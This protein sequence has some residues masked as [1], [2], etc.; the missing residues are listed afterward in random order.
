MGKRRGRGAEGR[1]VRR[2]K[3]RDVFVGRPFE[4]MPSETEWV[5]LRE[6]VP[7][8]T[9]PVRL[10]D[11]AHADRAVIVTSV[12]PLA[13]PALVKP[14]GRIFLAV[15]CQARSGDLSRDLAA[16]LELALVAGPT[17][18]V[19]VTDL[20]GPGP[21]LQDLLVD[22]ALDLTLHPT[23]G[24]WLDDE[25]HADP[26][27][28]ASLERANSTILPTARL[29]AAPSAYWCRTPEKAHLRWVLPQ[30]EDTAL[31]AVARLYAAGEIGL[32]EGT[33]YVGAFRAH[34]LLVPVWDLPREPAPD[35]YEDALAV[36]ASRYADALA[37]TGPLTPAER[38]VR[39]GLRGRQLTLR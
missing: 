1:R 34:G 16:A 9:A 18:Y 2:E 29:T 15:Q 19:P 37:E 31:D 6:L 23:F 28:A 14:D 11:P 27:V 32:G 12:L 21:R 5:A 10:A 39:D 26:E 8:A 3:V 24:F 4:G 30:D 22:D 25:P 17:S 13:N 20:P 38:R 35:A 33:R 36:L 7:A